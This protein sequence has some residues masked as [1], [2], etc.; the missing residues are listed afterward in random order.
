MVTALAVAL[1]ACAAPATAAAGSCATAWGT[2]VEQVLAGGGGEVTGVRAGTDA[3]WDRVVIDLAGPASGYTVTYV[4]EVR[5]EGSGAVVSVTGAAELQIS[6]S[7][8]LPLDRRLPPA[9]V[10]GYPTLRSVV[11]TGGFEGLGLGVGVR[12]RLPFRVL[13]LTG[14]DRLVVDIA[15]I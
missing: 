8:P 2:D 13:T 6:L 3:C 10:D 9:R 4:D 7:N 11:V 5:Q 14:P 12:D 1:L 15:H